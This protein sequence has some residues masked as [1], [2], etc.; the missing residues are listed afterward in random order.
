MVLSGWYNSGNRNSINF[1]GFFWGSVILTRGNADRMH[2]ENDV[3]EP[4]NTD[5]AAWGRSAHCH[6]TSF[7]VAALDIYDI[8]QPIDCEIVGALV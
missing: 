7:R 5:N 2:I 6:A 1:Y 8:S 3:V 4:S